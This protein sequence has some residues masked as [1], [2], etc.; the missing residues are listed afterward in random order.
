M[1]NITVSQFTQLRLSIKLFA[2]S[3]MFTICFAS[4]GSKAEAQIQKDS[5]VVSSDSGY[6]CSPWI[7]CCSKYTMN[8]HRS[9]TRWYSVHFQGQAGADTSCIAFLCALYSE[10]TNDVP[11]ITTEHIGVTINSSSDVTI[12]L[13]TDSTGGWSAGT[14]V[15]FF[16]CKYPN[17]LAD[18]QFVWDPEWWSFDDAHP[19]NSNPQD[20]NYGYDTTAHSWCGATS[21]CD[22]ACD[23][24]TKSEFKSGGANYATFCVT[25]RNWYHPADSIVITFK[26][27]ILPCDSIRFTGDSTF[28]IHCNE[29][30]LKDSSY[31]I[32]SL[33]P[34]DS[35]RVDTM[36]PHI[37]IPCPHADTVLQEWDSKRIDNV[38]STRITFIP[39]SPYYKL[40]PCGTWCFTIK[41]CSPSFWKNVKI[42]TYPLG[43]T[44]GCSSDTSG[45]AMKK[46]I[47]LLGAE[48]TL[49]DDQNYPNPLNWDNDFRTT[50]P[51]TLP[52]GGDAIIKI[53][54]ATG[55]EVKKETMTFSG[56]G[57]HFFYF[58]ATDLPAGKY[59]YQIEYPKGHVIVNK[60]MIVVK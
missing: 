23:Q 33:T 15:S 57:K 12:D 31:M 40:S 51:F 16:L 54:D 19:D 45:A 36:V 42:Q 44:N 9:G 3:Y 53:S 41:K 35:I 21:P 17:S 6:A 49:S 11:S 2:A 38:D 32:G 59:F 50:I 26:P 14:T 13:W 22:A 28:K 4:F 34:G 43:D 55:R 48:F 56:G 46:A 1:K 29:I 27:G 10:E 20:H 60:S 7:T 18:C 5:M 30:F 25:R 39:R 52:N 58:T 37:Y 47:G 24:V 8:I